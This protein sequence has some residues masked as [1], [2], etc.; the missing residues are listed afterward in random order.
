[1]RAPVRGKILPRRIRLEASTVC[2]LQ[3]PSCPTAAGKVRKTLG[4]GF[5]KLDDFKGIVDENPRVAEIE[6]S[7]WGEIFL[8]PELIPIMRH[9]YRRNVALRAGTGANLNTVSDDVLEALAKYHFRTITCA[10]DGASQQTYAQYRRQGHFENVIR[11]IRT[12]NRFKRE[13]HSAYPVLRWQFVAFGHNEHEIGQARKMA[14]DLQM[15]FWLKLSWEDLY[16]EPFSPIRDVDL[17]RRESGLGV[18]S[19]REYWDKY[20]RAYLNLCAGMWTSPQVNY[21]G[22]LLGCSVNYWADYGNVF[23]EGLTACVNNERIAA[24]REMLMGR[25]VITDDMPCARC[26]VYREREEHQDWVAEE[27]IADR[28]APSRRRIL[29]ENKVLGPRVKRGLAC[30]WGQMRRPFRR[31]GFRGGRR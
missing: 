1:M 12:I 3:C 22:R 20:G 13:Y 2:Q 16:S 11:N 27:D 6:L 8:N 9:A 4:A 17:I 14:A 5:L 10:L 15:E 29:L 30:L 7:N 26:K 18:A 24:A 21:D 25:R 23:Q 19:R 31:T 28:H